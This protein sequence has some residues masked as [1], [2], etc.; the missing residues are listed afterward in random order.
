MKVHDILE[1]KYAGHRDDRW[2]SNANI[3]AD[4]NIKSA[5][6]TWQAGVPVQRTQLEYWNDYKEWLEKNKELLQ[7]MYE[8]M[9]ADRDTFLDHT[10]NMSPF[11]TNRPLAA[12]AWVSAAEAQEYKQ[13]NTLVHD[14][15]DNV[16]HDYAIMS[17]N[18][19]FDVLGTLNDEH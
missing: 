19:M 4:N 11:D 15:Y 12:E 3:V 6:E 9:K 18:S 13:W 10:K 16:E 8:E 7:A 14:I 5:H 1:A 17:S 2:L